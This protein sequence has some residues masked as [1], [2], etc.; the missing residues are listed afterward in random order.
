M[1]TTTYTPITTTTLVSASNSITFNS[2]SGYTDLYLIVSGKS[3][4]ANAD[5]GL[6]FNG[7]TGSNYSRIYLYGSG[8]GSATSGTTANSSY[9]NLMNFSNVQ[10]EVNRVHIM[11]YSNS[12]TNKTALS[13]IDDVASLGTVAQAGL[14]RSTAAIT[15]LTVL[16]TGSSFLQAGTM[17][18]LYGIKAE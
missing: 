14:W 6:R 1:P 9:M 15:S 17:L 8:S 5:Y 12:T 7:D 3:D 13:R 18:T 2:F 16:T 4:G 11:N 10:P